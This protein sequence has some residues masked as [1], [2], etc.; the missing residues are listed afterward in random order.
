MSGKKVKGSGEK[1]EQFWSSIE[2]EKLDTLKYV[3]LHSGINTAVLQNDDGLTA[4]Q[5]AASADKHK[6]L[7]LMLD[8]MRQQRCLRDSI[9]VPEEETGRTALMLAAAKGSVK[10]VDHLLYYGAS[11]VL[12][13]ASGLTARDIAAA[14]KGNA[15]LL[16]LFEEEKEEAAAA[17]PAAPEDPNALTSTQLSKLKKKAMQDAERAAMLAAVSASAGKGEAGEADAATVGGGGGGGGG[18]GAWGLP[19]LEAPAAPAVW[20]EVAAAAAEKKRELRVERG[21]ATEGE[22]ESSSGGGGGGGGGGAPPAKLPPGVRVDPATWR[23]SLLNRLELHVAGMGALPPHVGHLSS[24]QTLILSG[25]DLVELPPTVACLAELKFLDLSRNRLAALPA[26]LESLKRLE[27][28]DVSDN[29]LAELGPV[30]AMTSLTT[31]LANR[32]AL[33][34]VPLNFKGLARLETLSLANNQI[35]ELPEDIGAPQLLAVLNVAENLLTDLPAGL[36]ELKEKK[37]R[38]VRV[39]GVRAR[40]QA[41]IRHP[42]TALLCPSPLH[43]LAPATHA[44]PS[45]T[46]SSSCFPTLLRTPNCARPL[47]KR[48]ARRWSRRCSRSLRARAERVERKSSVGRSS[49]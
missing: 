31:L 33:T 13:D 3:M 19:P 28:L 38:E 35:A 29:A 46:H 39:R 21:A 11:R 41:R 26:S 18:G 12:K 6:A 23:L 27:V 49:L 37:I 42:R 1:L 43:S 2:K 8:L 48:S 36:A 16:E 32:N 4:L 25:C 7:L 20:A 34:T 15:A 45:H 14:R 44:T 5:L 47:P 40:T 22:E 10:C 30:C 17:G 9:D 24:L